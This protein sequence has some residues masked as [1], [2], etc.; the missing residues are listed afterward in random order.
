MQSMN[1]ICETSIFQETDTGMAFNW[2]P[3]DAYHKN[4][5]I[6]TRHP[7][8]NKDDLLS[9]VELLNDAFDLDCGVTIA[10]EECLK[11]GNTDDLPLILN[12]LKIAIY[13]EVSEYKIDDPESIQFAESVFYD[14][15]KIIQKDK[16]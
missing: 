10:L 14:I 1:D 5:S 8:I 11:H 3:L 2:G 7:A 12:D 16:P 6:L 13:R 9:K 15:N 4:L